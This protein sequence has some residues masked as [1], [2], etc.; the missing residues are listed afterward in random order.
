MKIRFLT[1]QRG[2]EVIK[3]RW[4]DLDL[5]TGW[6]T[7]PGEH[8]KNGRA[9]RVPLVPEAIAIIKSQQKDK[10]KH[11]AGFEGRN[12]VIFRDVTPTPMVSLVNRE[13][14]LD[15]LRRLAKRV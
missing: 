9:H 5:D 6:W 1:A 8:A 3:M 13:Q 2:G 10:Q 11:N 14:I 15:E 12:L 4:R 7:I